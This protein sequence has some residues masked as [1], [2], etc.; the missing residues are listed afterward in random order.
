MNQ[1][2]GA[3]Q[4]ARQVLKKIRTEDAYAT[5]ALDAALKKGFLS[6]AD[7]ALATELVYGVLRNKTLLLHRLELASSGKI[8]VKNDVLDALLVAAHQIFLLDRIP[9]HAAVDDAVAHVNAITGGRLGAFANGLLRQCCRQHAMAEE[10]GQAPVVDYS[11]RF[12]MPEWVLQ[13][14]KKRTS[15]AERI[16]ALKGLNSKPKVYL[17]SRLADGHLIDALAG[18]TDA[19]V[20]KNTIVKSA[21]AIQ[22][23]GAPVSLQ[24]WKKG[25]FVIQDPAAQLV[26]ALVPRSAK[27]IMDACAGVGGKTI[28]ASD[29]AP[30]AGV[31]ALDVSK[32]KLERLLVAA[33]RV[34]NQRIKTKECDLMNTDLSNETLFDVVMLDAPCSGLGVLRRHP[35][36]K[37]RKDER[38]PSEFAKI[39]SMMLEKISHSVEPGGCLIYSVCTFTEAEGIGVIEGFLQKH[40]DFSLDMPTE[41]TEEVLWTQLLTDAGYLESWPHKHDMDGFFAAR[42]KK[43]R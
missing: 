31:L 8:K 5:I 33:K 15:K 7:K 42:L 41:D 11:I 29:L 24:A 30:M 16:D 28:H 19:K 3:R 37:W 17:R 27:R 32:A 34:G 12:S 23:A 21:L 35:E 39:Q 25:H 14:V 4:L 13:E 22:G 6:L 38:K 40:P 2:F 18:E 1:P 43:I 36:I 9:D 10:E 26:G 20:T